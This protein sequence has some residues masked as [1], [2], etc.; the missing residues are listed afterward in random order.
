M[1]QIINVNTITEKELSELPGIGKTKATAIVEHRLIH[2]KYHSIDDLKCVQGITNGLISRISQNYSFDFSYGS[3]SGKERKFETRRRSATG[4]C[5]KTDHYCTPPRKKRCTCSRKTGCCHSDV[6]SPQGSFSSVDNTH[7][8][9]TRDKALRNK[10]VSCG[11]ENSYSCNNLSNSCQAN[12][13]DLE[14]HSLRKRRTNSVTPSNEDVVACP[15]GVQSWLN[16]FDEW[17]REERL[18]AL[19][20][21]ISGCDMSVVRHM[22]VKIEPHF[23]RD[24]ISLLPKELSLYVLSYL[25]PKDLCRAAKTCRYW[26]TLSEDN[27]L[28]REK[29]CEYDLFCTLDDFSIQPHHRTV[30]ETGKPFK[31]QFLYCHK[32]EMNWRCQAL[33][34][35]QI[36]RG[37]DDHVVTCLEFD[38]VRIISGSDDNTL[39]VWCAVTGS[40][41]R[42]LIG[43]TGGVWS[44]HLKDSTVVSGS[45]DRTLRVWNADT[46]EC[47]FVL[48]GHTSTVRCLAMHQ[49]SIVSGSRDGTLRVWDVTDGSCL[50][51]LIGHAASVRCVQYDGTRVVS[52]A[53]D[54]LVKVWDVESETCLHTLS[55]HS[56]RVYSLQYDGRYIV[57]GSLDTSIRVWDA[58]SGELVHTLL[59]HQSLTSGME[60][61]CNYLVSGNADST[62]KI[63][64]IVSGRCLHTLSGPNKHQ[65]AVTSLHFNTK[66]VVTSSDDGSVKLWDMRTGEFIRDLVELDS[67]GS[68]GVVWRVKCN[69]KKLVCA[70]GS[71]NGTEET[72]LVVL[73][74]DAYC[75]S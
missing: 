20:E 62:V 29:C 63:W 42:T 21:L 16:T 51:V 22:M 7:N 14:Y 71:R 25:D 33:K 70:V 61:K 8:T 1:A 38:G 36:L 47:L 37:H 39:K 64:D 19:N 17:S 3:R 44:S 32:L 55:G 13:D 54:Y 50:H 10:F 34:P 72:K 69:E 18:L 26:R 73:D 11:V 65:S 23:Q 5:Q 57:S 75:N 41:I 67:G 12:D 9:S 27:L 56:N 35:A 28:W 2:S 66:F 68:G 49:D 60:L 58:D 43:H 48:Q 4:S 40:L 74:F 46:G 31:Q 52:G 59:G 24:F 45:T 6:C 30:N 15:S 53:Y